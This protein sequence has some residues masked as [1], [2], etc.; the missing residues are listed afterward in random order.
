MPDI[1]S[2]CPACGRSVLSP[3]G[4]D[5]FELRAT[6]ARD[7]LLGAVSYVGLLPAIVFVSVP[8]FKTERFVRFHSW[9]SI[10]FA[11]ATIVIALLMRVV[12]AFFSLFAGIGFLFGVLAMG[13]VLLAIVFL[14]LVLI[15]KAL[16]GGVHEL[17][18]LGRAA[19]RLSG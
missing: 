2:F 5:T 17:P 8:A 14:W 16:Q 13:L 4:A 11:I 6:S 9:Q 10:L 15:I 7:A 1:S 3:G 12:F 19:E 18:W